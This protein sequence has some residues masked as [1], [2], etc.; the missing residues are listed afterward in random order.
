MFKKVLIIILSFSLPFVVIE[1]FLRLFYPIPFSVAYDFYYE[2]DECTGYMMAPNNL[3]YY[4]EGIKVKTNSF[5]LR[6]NKEYR[7]KK[8]K[9]ILFIG[10]S[11]TEGTSVAEDK[12]FTNLIDSSLQDFEVINAGVPGFSPYQYFKYFECYADK[13]KPDHVVVDFF[14]GN[15]TYNGIKNKKDLPFVV[16]GKLVHDKVTPS[17]ITKIK[18]ILYEKFHLFRFIHHRGKTALLSKV[19]KS[20]YYRENC[21][22][23]YPHF[24]KTQKL[25]L[26]NHILPSERGEED[27]INLYRNLKLLLKMSEMAKKKEIGFLVLLIP[28]ENQ[29][30]KELQKITL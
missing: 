21:T 5:G 27:G 30:N 17:L 22:D 1:V 28:D 13:F 6:S 4:Q 10:D 20:W 15:D 24:I 19:D 7:E 23:F 8:N 26:K 12:R 9:R 3:S 11:F 14:V 16:N 18:I 2:E 25:R 29:I